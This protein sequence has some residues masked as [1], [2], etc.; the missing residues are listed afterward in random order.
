MAFTKTVSVYLCE[1]AHAHMCTLLF[2]NLQLA[3]CSRTCWYCRALQGN[4][5]VYIRDRRSGGGGGLLTAEG[6]L[7]APQP[8]WWMA[9]HWFTAQRQACI[10][11]QHQTEGC[12]FPCRIVLLVGRVLTMGSGMLWFESAHVLWDLSIKSDR[13]DIDLKSW[14][15]RAWQRHRE[16][17]SYFFQFLIKV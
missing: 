11:S 16:R 17:N 9:E 13:L 12:L 7:W 10:W 14:M 3:F 1:R 6:S 15:Y 5:F 8:D 2:F 4:I